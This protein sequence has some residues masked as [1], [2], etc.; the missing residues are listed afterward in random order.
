MSNVNDAPYI[1]KLLHICIYMYTLH[2]LHVCFN[3]DWLDWTPLHH[4]ADEGYADIAA[5]LIELGADVGARSWVRT[6][7]HMEVIQRLQNFVALHD[8]HQR[9][10]LG[11][12]VINLI[13]CFLLPSSF[14]I[15]HSESHN[16]CFH[17]VDW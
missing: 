13:G 16:F 9:G 15:C 10:N 5:V 17:T 8:T 14:I 1:S 7:L 11:S 2:L 12:F 6:F 4:A 3:Q